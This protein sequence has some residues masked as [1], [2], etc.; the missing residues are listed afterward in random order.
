MLTLTLDRI[1]RTQ[2]A[3]ITRAQALASGMTD[4]EIQGL[5]RRGIWMEIR[6]S[7]YAISGAP[8]S[9]HQILLASVLAHGRDAWSSH[10]TA[11][12]LWTL[13]GFDQP[14]LLE[15]VSTLSSGVRLDGVRGRRSGA[16]FDSDL[17]T[18][19][20]IPTVTAERALIDVSSRLTADRLGRVVDD[21]MRRRLIDLEEFRRCAGRL[22]PAPGRSMSKVH[23]VLGARIP[24]YDPGDS[25]LET[26]AL[27]ALTAA[28]LPPPK[29]QHRIVL[30]GKKARI[31]LA[32]PELKIAI[33]LDS[34]EYHG[35]NNHTAFNDDR[36]KKND[37]IVKGWAA[38]S[39]TES[40]TD[41][42]FVSMI[43]A[44]YEQAIERQ[45]AA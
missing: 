39:F 24:S 13:K 40:M 3:L 1:T 21:A 12:H 19:H 34:W 36:A 17:T 5:L 43:R 15:L 29:Q 4:G 22:L 9:W 35:R 18:R 10:A 42:Y 16:L 6:P 32:Y 11:G 31:D 28:G 7:V 30:N 25:D 41:E 27:R 23:A 26:R 8:Q 2:Y 20:K 44:L 38:P 33:E 37:L 45:S 14:D